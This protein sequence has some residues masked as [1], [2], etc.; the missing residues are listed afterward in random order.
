MAT[1]ETIEPAQ[2]AAAIRGVM[3]RYARDPQA[4]YLVSR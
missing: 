1:A 3:E 4:E 2:P